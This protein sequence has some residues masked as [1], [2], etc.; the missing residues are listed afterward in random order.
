[1]DLCIDCQANQASATSEECTVAWGICNVSS[2]LR[3][4]CRRAGVVKL[5]RWWWW[6]NCSTP[7]TFIAFRDGSRR[8][9][10]VRWI[11]ETGSFRNMVVEQL[12]G[13][14]IARDP[15]S[16]ENAQLG[17][18]R[19]EALWASRWHENGAQADTWDMASRGIWGILRY[20]HER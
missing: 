14:D 8:V 20:W 15:V 18:D 5:I 17:G 3:K 13:E 6:L 10:C 1:M 19:K 4:G 9:R 2:R 12:E 11:T 16:P 7:F